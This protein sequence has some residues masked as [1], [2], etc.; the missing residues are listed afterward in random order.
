MSEETACHRYDK[1][2][3]TQK[4]N[5]YSGVEADRYK[6]SCLNKGIGCYAAK[7]SDIEFKVIEREKGENI[8]KED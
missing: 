7:L 1:C 3:F 8:W 2:W 4:K 5:F 6:T